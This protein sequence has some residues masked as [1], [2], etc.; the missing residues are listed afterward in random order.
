MHCTLN[1]WTAQTVYSMQVKM[2][3]DA[4]IRECGMAK[5]TNCTLCH[6]RVTCI[7]LSLPSASLWSAPPHTIEWQSTRS[8]EFDDHGGSIACTEFGDDVRRRTA[9]V[10]WWQIYSCSSSTALN[11]R[12]GKQ[13]HGTP[14]VNIILTTV[15]WTHNGLRPNVFKLLM[16]WQSALSSSVR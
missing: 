4:F 8:M 11:I 14:E 13:L 9:T 6:V 12:L 3:S 1:C 15:R 5:V 7:P 2:L 16:V 10:N